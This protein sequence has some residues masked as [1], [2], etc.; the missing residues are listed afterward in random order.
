MLCWKWQKNIYRKIL[1]A[2]KRR[3]VNYLHSVQEYNYL[4]TN[5]RVQLVKT[6]HFPVTYRFRKA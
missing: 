6:F 5:V 3:F 4:K 2:V 1:L